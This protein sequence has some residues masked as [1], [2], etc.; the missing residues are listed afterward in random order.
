MLSKKKY[1]QIPPKEKR[2]GY[3]MNDL[4]SVFSH[5]NSKIG[6]NVPTENKLPKDKSNP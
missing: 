1:I 2:A 6:R 4:E 3:K 5:Y